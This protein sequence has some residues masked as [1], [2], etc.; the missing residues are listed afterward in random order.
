MFKYT[1]AYIYI[2]RERERGRGR[3]KYMK[4]ILFF[5]DNF[6]LLQSIIFVKLPKD[7][8]DSDNDNLKDSR[9]VLMKTK[10]IPKIELQINYGIYI[11]IIEI[12]CR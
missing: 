1:Y 5:Q 7:N 6:V 2:Y 8:Y 3:E 4:V 9:Y 12:C 11:N 10:T